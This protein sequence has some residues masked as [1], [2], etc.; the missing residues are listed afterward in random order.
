MLEKSLVDIVS[1]TNYLILIFFPEALMMKA[2]NYVTVCHIISQ[3]V[4]NWQSRSVLGRKND[5]T[6]HGAKKIFRVT[7][8]HLNGK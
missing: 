1:Y 7:S 4:S 8:L 3:P 2:G 5:L 6:K